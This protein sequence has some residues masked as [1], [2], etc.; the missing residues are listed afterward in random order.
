M[1]ITIVI[2]MAGRGSR[3]RKAGYNMPK[4]QII[5]H[6]KTL[7]DW[8]MISLKGYRTRAIQ[9][10]F[11]VRKEDHAKAFLTE[12]CSVQGIYNFRIIELD[13]MTDGQA[14]TAM[15]A[16]PYWNK[17]SALLI[18]NIDTYI[19][20]GWLNSNELK[21]DG[22]IPC[23]KGK[24]DHWSFVKIDSI[25]RATEVREKIRISDYC[26]LG[27][28]YFRSCALYEKLYCEYYG[29]DESMEKGEKYIA[30]LY[31][32]LILQGGEVYIS[33]IDPAVVHVLGTPEELQIFLNAT[34]FG[35]TKV[36]TD[37]E[38]KNI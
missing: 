14:T 6:G 7:F 37:E 27:A 18:Y 9:H 29:V 34:S 13:E 3:F 24:G 19:E 23:F 1:D 20:E 30:P 11:I 35:G 33:D 4:Y 21:G 10:I 32:H 36:I 8:S 12:H 15:L 28:Y 26:T 2:T 38:G 16:A 22:F 5:A 17:E 25:K 31:N